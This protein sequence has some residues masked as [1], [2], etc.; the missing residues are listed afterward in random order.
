VTSANDLREEVAD[1]LQVYSA[2]VQHFEHLSEM[3]DGL[4]G[5]TEL[6]KKK[7]DESRTQLENLGIEVK[8]QADESLVVKEPTAIHHILVITKLLE[9]QAFALDLIPLEEAVTGTAKNMRAAAE[10]L[11]HECTYTIWAFYGIGWVLS[12]G[13]VISGWGAKRG[14]HG[15]P[16]PNLPVTHSARRR[17][18]RHPNQR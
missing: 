11:D 8:K 12:F 18:V 14:K 4:P 5:R 1:V 17:S 2:E 15:S 9:V 6:L 7:R 10:R 3:L 13:G 16:A